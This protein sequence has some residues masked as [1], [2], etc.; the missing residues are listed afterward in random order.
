MKDE[1]F[2]FKK[3]LT[4]WAN[5]KFTGVTMNNTWFK[6][7]E[8]ADKHMAKFQE[9]QNKTEEKICFK[10]LKPCAFKNVCVFGRCAI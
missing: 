3:A 1:P 9:K 5:D 2:N 6:D 10:T 7:S 8:S 4:D